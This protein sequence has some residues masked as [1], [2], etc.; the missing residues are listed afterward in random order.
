MTQSVSFPKL[1]ST[2][3]HGN[4]CIW[5]IWTVDNIIHTRFGQ[6]GGKIQHITK[7]IHTGK[8]LNKKNA[9]T[10]SEQAA[11]EAQ[12]M[13]NK[14]KDTGKFI[15]EEEKGKEEDSRIPHWVQETPM[16]AT[17]YGDVSPPK[18]PDVWVQPKL[19]GMRAKIVFDENGKSSMYTRQNKQISHLTHLNEYFDTL[20]NEPRFV[21][22]LKFPCFFDGEIFSDKL[23]FEELSGLCRK[24]KPVKNKTLQME[25]ENKKKLLKVHIFDVCIQSTHTFGERL[26]I[27]NEIMTHCISKEE[28]IEVVESIKCENDEQMHKMHQKY[29]DDGHEGIIIRNECG[30]YKGN[31]YRSPHLQKL[32]FKKDAEY[33]IVGFKEGTGKL[34]N[35]VIWKCVNENESEFDVTPC[36]TIEY[37]KE[38]FANAKSYVGKLL[39]VE[40]QEM[41]SYGVPRF[42]IGKAIRDYE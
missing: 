22:L 37:R 16:L 18:Y 34:K 38:L 2:N 41:T 9:T 21:R 12:S 30:L 27:L 5:Y 6:V 31:Q 25:I 7:E 24:T 32:K 29:V 35:T 28:P 10:P 1:F 8:N 3:S 36:G 20:A 23:P 4:E 14:K 15:T 42:P 26:C 40:F 39:T 33:E 19:D 17:T 11:C 13:W